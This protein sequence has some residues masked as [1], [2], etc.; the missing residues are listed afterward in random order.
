MAVPALLRTRL[1]VAGD[2]PTVAAI[3]LPVMRWRRSATICSAA[4]CG[5]GL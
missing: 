2:T 1:T 5:V 3:C 4:A